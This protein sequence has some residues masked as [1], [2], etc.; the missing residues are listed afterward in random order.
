MKSKFLL[1]LLFICIFEFY[2]SNS[3]A[4]GT[5]TSQFKQSCTAVQESVCEVVKRLGR[6]INLGNMLEAPKEGDWGVRVEPKYI[7]MVAAN[8]NN[9]RLPVRWSNHASRDEAAVLDPIFATRVDTVIDSLLKKDVYVI[10]DMHHYGQ[11][12]GDQLLKG[13]YEVSSEILEKRMVNIWR[14]L[15][16]R[17]KDR[18][19]KL[20]FELLNEPHGKLDSDRWNKL[21]AETL[22]AVR[23]TN[24]N[25]IVMIGPTSFNAPKDLPKLKLPN[26]RNLI[27]Q[28]HSYLPFNFTHQGV[29][30]LPMKLPADVKCCDEKQRFEL[31]EDI[32]K[33]SQWSLASGY[34]VY[35][36]EFGSNKIADNDSRVHYARSVRVEAERR[37]IP[38]A[39]WELASSFGIFDPKTNTWNS[40]LRRALLNK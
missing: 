25:R 8:F 5:D 1:H 4:Q 17:Y 26:D 31:A 10:L 7:E 22:V 21:L 19:P 16:E 30:Y 11:L 3:I 12:F 33:A 20:I 36:G 14:Q 24:P 6:G 28:F 37:G 2:F 38:W 35:L 29:K 23:I 34:P 27:V 40:E 18:S 32:E 39:Y 13:E 15:A 9:V